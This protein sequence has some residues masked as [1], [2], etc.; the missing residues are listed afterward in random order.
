M[1]RLHRWW[2]GRLEQI[3]R[4]KRDAEYERRLE[5]ARRI[6]ADASARRSALFERVGISSKEAHDMLPQ[7]SPVELMS[8][9][10][11]AF[12]MIDKLE[13]RI[14]ELEGKR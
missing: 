9:L 6:L 13:A 3:E 1:S 8:I 11:A 12:A 10:G 4:A 5:E 14:R 7:H 2:P